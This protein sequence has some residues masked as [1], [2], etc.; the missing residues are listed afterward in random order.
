MKMAFLNDG[1][2]RTVVKGDGI[3]FDGECNNGVCE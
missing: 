2:S 3:V 1:T